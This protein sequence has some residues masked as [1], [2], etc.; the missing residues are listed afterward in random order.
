MVVRNYDILIKTA[1]FLSWDVSTYLSLQSPR[2]ESLSLL[3]KP[4]KSK[5]RPNTITN[6]FSSEP[7][8]S[9]LLPQTQYFK[10]WNE[11]SYDKYIRSNVQ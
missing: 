6:Q 3:K 9:D 8:V 5:H 2:Q 11:T 4:E 7:N 10:I 1:M